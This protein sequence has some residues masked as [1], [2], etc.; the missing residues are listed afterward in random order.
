M[1]DG[2]CL[3]CGKAIPQGEDGQGMHMFVDMEFHHPKL[4]ALKTIYKARFACHKC[5]RDIAN[6]VAD[7]DA[8][9]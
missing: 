4:P 8:N 5:V 1:A 9:I 6:N 2:K 7:N 3:L